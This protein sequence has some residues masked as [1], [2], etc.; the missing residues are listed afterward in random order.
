MYELAL[1]KGI[2]RDIKKNRVTE[3]DFLEL[4][5]KLIESGLKENPYKVTEKLEGSK[6]K[7]IRKYKHDI[8]GISYRLFVYIDDIG[9]II[10]LLA[11]EQRKKCYNKESLERI[12]NQVKALRNQ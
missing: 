5:R 2:L 11:F 3:Y 4:E 7:L 1:T 9:K 8:K 6:N 12:V 10:Y